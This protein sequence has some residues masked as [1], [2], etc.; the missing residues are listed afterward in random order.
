MA[1]RSS[2]PIRLGLVAG[3]V[4]TRVVVDEDIELELV[5]YE[6]DDELNGC[7]EEDECKSKSC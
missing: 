7:C 4:R 3:A 6:P 2:P 1:W 5:G